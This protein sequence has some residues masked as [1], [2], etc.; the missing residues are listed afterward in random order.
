MKHYINFVCRNAHLHTEICNAET[1]PA[2]F[3]WKVINELPADSLVFKWG[4]DEDGKYWEDADYTE[5]DLFIYENGGIPYMLSGLDIPEFRK[6]DY[7]WILRNL[8]IN[9]PPSQVL[10]RIL[11]ILERWYLPF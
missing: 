9:N 11:T 10:S 2:Q 4:F 7:G 8:E 5:I 1:I 3:N 6:T